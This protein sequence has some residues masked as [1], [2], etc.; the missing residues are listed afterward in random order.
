MR[1]PLDVSQ[2]ASVRPEAS[3]I[4]FPWG[5]LK[6]GPIGSW[7]DSSEAGSRPLELPRL[8]FQIWTDRPV[9]SA[10]QLP[11]GGLRARPREPAVALA[12]N[13]AIRFPV[14]VSHAAS[15]PPFVRV[16]IRR[17]SSLN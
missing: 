3:A 17:P 13:V 16:T 9:R 7:V 2:I 8:G 14:S 15:R 6:T 11:S 4:H 1:L 5:G 10:T 12:P